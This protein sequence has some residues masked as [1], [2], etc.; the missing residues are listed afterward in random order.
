MW[1]N[2]LSQDNIKWK[3]LKQAPSYKQGQKFCD[4]CLTEKLA[5]ARTST[6]PAYLNK[7]FELAQK[8]R[9]K[10]KYKLATLKPKAQVDLAKNGSQ[11]TFS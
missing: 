4:L 6:D 8:C 10:I 1:D 11:Q 3:I 5:I 9:H 7:R 2:N